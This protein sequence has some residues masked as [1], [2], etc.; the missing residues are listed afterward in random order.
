MVFKTWKDAE[1]EF[2]KTNDCLSDDSDKEQDRIMV[3]LEEFGH[4]V[5]E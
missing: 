1:N 2:Y 5:G 3:W 4:E